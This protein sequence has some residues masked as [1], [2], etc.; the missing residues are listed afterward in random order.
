MSWWEQ[1]RQTATVGCSELAL[2]ARPPSPASRRWKERNKFLGSELEN[3]QSRAFW[4][5]GVSGELEPG[6]ETDKVPGPWLCPAPRSAFQAHYDNVRD[7]SRLGSL[8]PASPLLIWASTSEAKWHS[9][10]SRY[11]GISG[12]GEDTWFMIFIW[13]TRSKDEINS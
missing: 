11:K 8:F 10:Y 1:F 3:G 6:L 5:V 12:K 13:T 9:R 2:K 4:G 7:L